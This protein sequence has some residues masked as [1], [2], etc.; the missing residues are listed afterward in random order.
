MSKHQTP[1]EDIKNK[2]K[3]IQSTSH[4]EMPKAVHETS[5]KSKCIL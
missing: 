3:K 2:Q 5:L 1:V 4:L